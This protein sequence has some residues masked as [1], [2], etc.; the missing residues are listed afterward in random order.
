MDHFYKAFA[1]QPLARQSGSIEGLVRFGAKVTAIEI[2]GDKVTIAYE[3]GG[4]AR[5][6]STDFCVCTIPVPIFRTLRTNLPASFMDAA[7]KLPTQAAGKVGWQA[8]RFWETKDNIYGGISWTTDVITQIWYPSS[9][10]LSPKGVITGAYMYG[11]PADDF[12]ARP[13]AERLRIAREQGERLHPG[14][15][16][17]VEQGIGI[18]WNNMEFA[19]FAW[20]NEGDPAFGENAEILSKPRGRFQIA[21]DQVTFWSGWQEGALISA[22]EAVK[23]IDRQVNPTANR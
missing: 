7:R 8:E 14:F 19:R 4:S 20:A 18:G 1:R 3:D 22:W 9:G 15:S 21:G 5:V 11:P 23:A 10:Y 13:L 12:N 16:K 2:G 6:L 17:Y